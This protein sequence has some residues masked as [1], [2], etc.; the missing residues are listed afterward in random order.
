MGGRSPGPICS[1]RVGDDWIDLGTTCRTL[2]DKPGIVAAQ[3]APE[4]R[5]RQAAVCG[6]P[7]EEIIHTA[8]VI[9][10]QD[11]QELVPRMVLI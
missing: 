6:Q 8:R 7:V 1:S 4:D 10:A 9:S 11:Q 2:V 5:D 3:D